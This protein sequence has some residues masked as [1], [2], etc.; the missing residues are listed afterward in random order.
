MYGDS[1]I[2][3]HRPSHVP[4]LRPCHAGPIRVARAEREDRMQ[5]IVRRRVRLSDTHRPAEDQTTARRRS[6]GVRVLLPA[7]SQ[8]LCQ[9]VLRLQGRGEAG[10]QARTGPHRHAVLRA[11]ERAR[12][13]QTVHAHET[14]HSAEHEERL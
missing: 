7:V 1:A 14:V 13:R 4:P 2:S 12:S 11:R 5:P 8:R 3:Q 6:G 10:T 9:R